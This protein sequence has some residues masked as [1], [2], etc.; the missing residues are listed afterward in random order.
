[1]ST[2]RTLTTTATPGVFKRGAGYVVRFRDP[3]GR[4]RQRAARTLAEARRLRSELGADVSR[5]EYRPE[6]KISFAAYVEMWA[7]S[8][9][10]RTARGLRAETLAE[11]VRDLAPAVAHFGR[12]RLSEIGPTDVRA[13]ARE[14][15]EEGHKPATIRR[16]LAPVK[17]LF[18]EAVE[19]GLLRSNPTAG[20]KLAP[21]PTA[22]VEAGEETVKALTAEQL[23]RVVAE[24][25]AGVAAAPRVRPSPDCASGVRGARP[26]VE[27][28]RPRPRRA[29]PARSA[30][31]SRREARASQER[32]RAA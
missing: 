16:K 18:A 12:R 29:A 32:P 19:D 31:Y 23:A 27:R 2:T 1:M 20:V 5:G 14:L 30:P 28:P 11:Y 9:T 26:T 24:V 6:A 3:S 21:R 7:A 13:Y 8:Y 15:A 22:E 25:P 10:G 17:C 4:Q